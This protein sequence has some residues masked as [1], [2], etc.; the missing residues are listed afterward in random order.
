MPFS[1]AEFLKEN[2]NANLVKIKNGGHLNGSAGFLTLPQ[3]LKEIL[4]IV[5]K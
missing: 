2:L 4:K 5:N 1:H 3:A